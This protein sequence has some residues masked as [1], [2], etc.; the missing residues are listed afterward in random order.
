LIRAGLYLRISRDRAQLRSAVRRQEG[1]CREAA[2]RLGWSVAQVY[3]DNGLSA[4]QFATKPRAGYEQLLADIKAGRLDAVVVWMEDRSHRQVIELAAFVETCRVAGISRYASV[5][6]EYDLSDPDQVTMLLFVARTSEAEVNRISVRVKRK[7]KE[8]AD[9]GQY[10][11]GPKPYGYQ[12][13]IKGDNGVV[14]N[15]GG[16]GKTILEEEA[17]VIR[18]AARRILNGESLRSLVIDLNRRGIPA[19]RGSLWTRRTLKV[20]LTHPRV[21]GLRQHQGIVVGKAGWPPILDHETWRRV[22]LVLLSPDRSRG[23][24]TNRPY[25]LSG[26]LH[27]GKCGKRLVGMPYANGTRAYGCDVG[28]TYRGC[29]GVRRKAES[30]ETLVLELILR[31]LDANPTLLRVPDVFKDEGG[32][33]TISPAL[34][35]REAWENA[36][37]ASRRRLVDAFIESVVVLPQAT[38]RFDP[39]SI[40]VRWRPEVLLLANSNSDRSEGGISRK[41]ELLDWAL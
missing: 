4:S 8:L 31:H 37:Q 18:D 9:S 14:I 17:M 23:R 35:V 6:T 32:Q 33:P 38:S 1:D 13:P 11:G 40:L 12:G 36:S 28:T 30:V 26:I 41:E 15:Q 20:I 16:I 24:P 3:I 27:C 2:R 39:S 25:L 34:S 21:A 10:H 5:G 19:P 22:R 7:H 29:G